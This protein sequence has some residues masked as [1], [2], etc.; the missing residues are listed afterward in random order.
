MQAF[1]ELRDKYQIGAFLRFL[2][3]LILVPQELMWFET[4]RTHSDKNI[5]DKN[6]KTATIKRT[7]FL[8]AIFLS[9]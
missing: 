6:M 4:A 1:T 9:K 3:L 5:G 8:S 2:I 7:I